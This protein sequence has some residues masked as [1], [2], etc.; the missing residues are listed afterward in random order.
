[1]DDFI[2]LGPVL[3][4]FEHLLVDFADID[5]FYDAFEDIYITI[6]LFYQLLYSIGLLL[7]VLDVKI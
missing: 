4:E 1:L 6:Q 2:E 7:P 5:W 3:D